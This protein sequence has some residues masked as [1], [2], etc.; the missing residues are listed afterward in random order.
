MIINSGQDHCSAYC[1]NRNVYFYTDVSRIEKVNS[2]K[3][4]PP[5]F[6]GLVSEAVIAAR[7]LPAGIGSNAVLGSTSFALKPLRLAIEIFLHQVKNG[8]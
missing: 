3:L 1:K 5:D 6:V 8:C 2:K 7:Y 4:P